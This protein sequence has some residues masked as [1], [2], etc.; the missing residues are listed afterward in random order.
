MGAAVITV[1]LTVYAATATAPATA[2]PATTA[3][4]VPTT[5]ATP[6]PTATPTTTAPPIPIGVPTTRYPNQT[7]TDKELNR[8][9]NEK[10]RICNAGYAANC[11]PKKERVEDIPCSAIKLSLQQRRACKAARW[12]VQNTCFGGQPDATHKSEMENVQNGINHC[13]A[14]ELVNCAKG[15]PKA[16]L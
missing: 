10:G 12:L 3:T 4:P 1:Q 8:L 7:C 2:A 14:L 6:K 13:E 11:N 15:H 16:G 5:T 9:Q